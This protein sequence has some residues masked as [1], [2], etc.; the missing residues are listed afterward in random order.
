MSFNE[1]DIETLTLGEIIRRQRE[2]K[3]IDL[4]KLSE[5]TGVS[6]RNLKKLEEGDYESLPA[7]IYIESFI[8]KCEKHLGF[9]DGQLLYLYKNERKQAD[10]IPDQNVSKISTRSFILTPKIIWKITVALIV[11]IILVY[12]SMQLSYLLGAPK[13]VVISPESDIITESEE[14]VISGSTQPDNKVTINNN[15]VFVDREGVFSEAIPLQEGVNTI[16]VKSVN[17][18]GKESLVIR[19]IMLQVISN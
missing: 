2:S 13:L 16:E 4:K 11:F 12:F 18:F 9:E 19:R 10:R 8:L 7:E 5:V 3:K 6:V 17:R 1:K 15:D 14:I